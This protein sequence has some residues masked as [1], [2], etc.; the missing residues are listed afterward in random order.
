VRLHVRG[1]AYLLRSPMGAFEKR[2]DPHHFVRIHRSAIA[3]L[4]RVQ[5]IEPFTRGEYVVM[6]RD[7]ARL[8]SGR[9]HAERLR[10]V[11]RTG[12]M[13]GCKRFTRRDIDA[14]QTTCMPAAVE[15]SSDSSQARP[16]NPVEIGSKTL[17][18]ACRTAIVLLR[19]WGEILRN[20]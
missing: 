14:R 20:E 1:A 19:Y 8:R 17:T 12:G 4:D 2:L 15:S 7:E 6:T 16:T 3:N 18:I 13:T 10:A 5:K 11:V 9:A